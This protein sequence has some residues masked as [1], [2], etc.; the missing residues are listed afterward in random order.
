MQSTQTL[1]CPSSK[2]SMHHS[3]E[4]EPAALPT[5]LCACRTYLSWVAHAA[6]SWAQDQIHSQSRWIPHAGHSWAG[7]LL[8]LCCVRDKPN[9]QHVVS[10]YCLARCL[11]GV[12]CGRLLRQQY[13][14]NGSGCGAEQQHFN[15]HVRSE[16]NCL[17]HLDMHMQRCIYCCEQPLQRS[18]AF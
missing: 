17:R 12:L 18:C 16:S 15:T 13:V 8:V 9:H 6:A 2:N 1:H 4:V 7:E 3:V 11:L 10:A 5:A 14:R